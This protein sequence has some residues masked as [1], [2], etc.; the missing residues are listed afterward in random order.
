MSLKIP[1]IH[2]CLLSFADSGSKSSQRSRSV[3]AQNHRRKKLAAFEFVTDQILVLDSLNTLSEDRYFEEVETALNFEVFLNRARKVDE[4]TAEDM[5]KRLFEMDSTSKVHKF[6]LRVLERLCKKAG[7]KIERGSV[8][9]LYARSLWLKLQSLSFGEL[10]QTA[11]TLQSFLGRGLSETQRRAALGQSLRFAAV[12]SV[13]RGLEQN[14]NFKPSLRQAALLCGDLP[15]EIYIESLSLPAVAARGRFHQFLDRSASDFFPTG[16]ASLVQRAVLLRGFV[17]LRTGR[18]AESRAT[19]AESVR[20]AQGNKDDSTLAASLALLARLAAAKGDFAALRAA[21]ENFSALRATHGPT[22]PTLAAGLLQ[23]DLEALADDPQPD[24][25]GFA[26]SIPAVLKKTFNAQVDAA[27]SP[28]RP[29]RAA[30]RE[31]AGCGHAVL[32]RFVDHGV[33]WTGLAGRALL[34]LRLSGAASSAACKFAINTALRLAE[35]SLPAARRF[36]RSQPSLCEFNSISAAFG[37]CAMKATLFLRLESPSRARE[38][39]EFSKIDALDAAEADYLR[40]LAAKAA[41]DFSSDLPCTRRARLVLRGLL[42]ER[43]LDEQDPKGFLAELANILPA[44]RRAG[45][46][47]LEARLRLA[48][49][50]AL[51]ALRRPELASRELEEVELLALRGDSE[52]QSRLHLDKA[53]SLIQADPSGSEIQRRLALSLASAAPAA[54]LSSFKQALFVASS[55]ASA[56]GNLPEAEALAARFMK[57][58]QLKDISSKRLLAMTDFAGALR[59][60]EELSLLLTALIPSELRTH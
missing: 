12:D 37:V 34:P 43:R 18:A 22:A 60:G 13:K 55:L 59:F 35:G 17:E 32:R 41:L 51:S 26:A 42:A 52:L 44:A 57:V 28:R 25:R 50:E 1:P 9:V 20:F 27:F 11:E 33:D 36:F 7:S 48:A 40:V 19:L 31:F 29:R 5:S 46:P 21:L 15:V 38:Q 58:E 10:Q 23:L 8:L 53:L 14:E 54:D 30:G 16:S 24:P 56:R 3:A 47:E 39:L 4:E 6:L 49:S 45:L 2:I